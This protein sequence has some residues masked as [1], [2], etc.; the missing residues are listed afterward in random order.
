MT[1]DLTWLTLTAVL[2]GLMWLP[3]TLERILRLGLL[4]A[5]GYNADSGVAGFRQANETPPAWARRA[6]AAHANVTE[7]F[8]VFVA[9]VLTAHVAGLAEG[10]V[11]TAA[12][13]Y[14]FARL[15]H[16]VCYWLAVPLLRTLSFFAGLGAFIA[17][18]IVLLSAA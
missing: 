9:L 17:M 16:A 8:P 10:T 12:A 6:Y 3:Y 4:G 7:S 5:T 2:V 14:F 18:A 13:V 1:A 15:G 11:T